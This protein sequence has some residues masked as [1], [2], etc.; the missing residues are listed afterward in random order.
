MAG[1]KKKKKENAPRREV[2]EH[3]LSNVDKNIPLLKKKK[4]KKKERK[5]GEE[6]EILQLPRFMRR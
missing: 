1:R 6:R 2:T 4:K 3:T 5:E